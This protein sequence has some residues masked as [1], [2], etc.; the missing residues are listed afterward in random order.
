[1]R[2]WLFCLLLPFTVNAVVVSEEIAIEGHL[3]KVLVSPDGGAPIEDMILVA[4]GKDAAAGDG[5]V[6]EGFGVASYYMPNRR[7]NEKL[8]VLDTVTDRPVLRYSYDCDG[9]NIQGLHVSRTMEPMLD[10]S[11]IRITWRVENR[12]QLTQWV[13]PWVRNPV[14]VG[15]SVDAQDRI[16]VPT[17]E[18]IIEV[19]EPGYHA[20][21]R[22]WVA[23]TDRAAQE[24][25]YGVFN[26]DHTHSFLILR[27][28]EHNETSFQT[29]FVPRAFPPGSSWETV[30]RLNMV[31][32]L[33]HV[34]FATDELAAQI[35]YTPGRVEMILA[36]VK[37]LPPMQ[38]NATIVGPDGESWKLPAKK[39]EISPTKLTR[40]T[41]E[42]TAPTD[43]AYD[44][45]AQLLVD[46]KPYALGKDTGSP[47][48]GIDLQF[49]AGSG[50]K[51]P[52]EAWSDAPYALDRGPRKL[53]RPLLHDGEAVVWHESS[54]EK[55]GRED[56]PVATNARERAV[57]I[58]LAK[59]EAESFQIVV[60]PKD[61]GH[62]RVTLDIAALTH[63]ET[64]ER[65]PADAVQAYN[66]A[67][68][69]VTVPSHYESASGM[70]PD[71][72]PEFA[73]FAA[74]ANTSYPIW[75]TVKAPANAT[76]GMYKGIISIAGLGLEPIELWLEVE[77]FDFALPAT[78]TM[79]TDFGFWREGAI[80]Q[81]KAKGFTGSTE[82]LLDRYRANAF[83]HRVTL[84]ELCAF[85][86][87][88]AAYAS[89]LDAY[90]ATAKRYVG[91]GATSLELPHRI[92]NDPAALGAANA[93]VKQHQLGHLAFTQ[94]AAAPLEPAWPRVQE[95]IASW[96][97][98]APDIP[99][100]VTTQGLNAFLPPEIDIWAIHS[101]L[102]D[103]LH[104][105]TV[106]NRVRQGGRVW[107][108]VNQLPPRPY[109]NLLLDFMGVE[110]RALFWQAWAMGAEG[111]HYGGI[112]FSKPGV[113]PWES[114]LDLT[115][116][117]GDGFLV[118]PGP[119]GPVNSIRWE[120][121][122][123]GLEDCD[124][125][126]LLRDRIKRMQAIGGHEALVAK[127]ANVFYLGELVPDLVSFPRDPAPYLAKREAI[128][129]MIVEIDAALR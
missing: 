12:G 34:D 97:A 104:G 48:G 66:V 109:A 88:Q 63:E 68:V 115:P 67:Y 105:Q 100:M 53:E 6:Q 28:D 9:P 87:P 51:R 89:A 96:H 32:G 78:P 52:M 75:F 103:T 22:N 21:A 15:G 10:E 31:R 30:Y 125:L 77:V 25:L 49:V 7:L 112:N 98:A 41:Y 72:L 94:L 59:N 106:S 11:S 64:G 37:A 69:P 124:Y 19:T 102:M 55:I 29:A 92:L 2:F 5:L 24:T 108:F 36:P 20:A 95:A 126:S 119:N 27:D 113:D 91:M 50:R 39:F 76:A 61:T 4:T 58:Q 86:E 60:R 116:A 128:A 56:Y 73:P 93:F 80:E 83:A 110:H 42:W 45:L 120:I 8:E 14:R 117:Q 123:D 74:K 38:I 82:S 84:R 18:G 40:C 122:R 107:W 35:E 13:A 81:T 62:S 33:R 16:D 1:M 85:P 70:W 23:V 65:F 43:G 127:A 118:Y 114:Q 54:M 57:R 3:L 17:F 79:K 44:F 90:A 121:V 101:Q 71:P 129:R 47:H 26:I 111:F 46:G 99:V